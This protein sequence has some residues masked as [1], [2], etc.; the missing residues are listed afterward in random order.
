MAFFTV[1]M[2]I[3]LVLTCIA[4]RYI[5]LNK[6]NL[7]SM[8]GMMAAMALGMMAGLL[9]GTIFGDIY[10]GNLFISTLLGM[11]VGV[12]FG[13]IAGAPVS[14]LAFMDGL[15]SGAMGGM[16]G[17][18]LGEMIVPANR[19][20]MIKI[21]FV[22]FVSI[23]LII[24]YMMQ[25]EVAQVSGK[26]RFPVFQN[27]LVMVVVT[28]TFFVGYNEF[29]SAGKAGEPATTIQVEATEFAF[30]PREVHV[31]AN[32]PVTLVF[33]NA[34]KQEHDLEIVGLK[35]EILEQQHSHDH[36]HQAG[37]GLVH[38]HAVAGETQKVTFVPLQKGQFRI[39]CTL[40]GH[41]E[42][43]MQGAITVM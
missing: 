8:T 7:S 13:C 19:L 27:P 35:A 28:G 31:K 39:V 21:L 40:P 5:A 30:S 26:T 20:L 10:S 23:T 32:E 41:R 2:L 29:L 6:K 36:S 14:F 18:M 16:M 3:A 24:L 4:V 15:L 9:Y 37:G 17:A 25:Q 33:Q 34:G 38:V 11:A 42:S 12:A 22:L 1:T 43:G